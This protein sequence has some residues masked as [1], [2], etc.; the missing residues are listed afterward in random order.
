MQS[1]NP[2]MAAV[3]PVG[4]IERQGVFA[5]R[6]GRAVSDDAPASRLRRE[7]DS[8]LPEVALAKVE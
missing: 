2:S 6:F 1:V 7:G 5:R 8:E 3:G 4:Q